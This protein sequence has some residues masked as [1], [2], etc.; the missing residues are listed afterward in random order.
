MIGIT[1][2]GSWYVYNGEIDKIPTGK[3]EQIAKSSLN[4]DTIAD[5]KG[6]HQGIFTKIVSGTINGKID[7]IFPVLHGINGE[8]GTVQGLLELSGIPYVGTGVLGSSL[9]MDKGM[10]KII[11]EKIGIPQAKYLLFTKNEIKENLDPI[12]ARVKNE[13]RYPCFVKPANAGSSVGVTKS[14]DINELINGIKLATKYDRRILIEEFVEGREIECAVLGNEDAK[15]SVLGEVV[16][17]NEFYDY[18]AKYKNSESK[19]IV[20]A[21]LSGNTS[22]KVRDYAVKAFKALDCAGLSR[23]D[24]F[25]TKDECILI[26]EINTIPGF[27]NISMYAKMW[28]K[29]GIPYK[30]LI[31]KLLEYAVERYAE[32]R[33]KMD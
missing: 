27:T 14:H 12:L 21:K 3:W 13:L 4:N 28:E 6:E 32:S 16:T 15:A 1:K 17:A 7:V 25:V 33:R 20:P 19:T 29:T 18:E 24:F 23:V 11:F 26:N 8:D 5:G 22:E 30:E 31:S 2:D 9:A 10:S